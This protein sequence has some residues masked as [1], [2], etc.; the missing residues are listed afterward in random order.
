[1]VSTV[2][3]ATKN[4]Y[5]LDLYLSPA[6]A[7][8]DQSNP[9]GPS[10]R[11]AH[12]ST[13][14]DCTPETFLEDVG[15]VRE[16]F[17]K[18]SLE[19]ETYHVILSHS[20]EELDP[21]SEFEVWL[22]HDFAREQMARAFPGRQIKIVTQAD[23]GR[24]EAAGTAEKIWVKG[25]VHSHC[26][27]A[28]VA[29]EAV[30][31]TWRDAD[32]NSS[33]AH[34]PAGRAFSSAMKN[35]HR[36]RA[37]TDEVVLQRFQYDNQ[38]FMQSCR[39]HARTAGMGTGDR[40][41]LARQAEGKSSHYDELRMRLRIARAQATDWDDYTARLAADGVE[42]KRR[43]GHGDGV[44]YKWLDTPPARAGGRSGV[45]D[46]YKYAAV[47]EQCE[48][49]AQ[50]LKRGEEL[51]TPARSLVVPTSSLAQD[52][53]RP[54][55][56]TE[57][58]KPP[59]QQGEDSYAAHVRQTGGTYEGRAA[60]A[61]ATGEP[62][63]GVT[64][65]RDTDDRV[66][67]AVDAGAGPLVVDVDPA[68]LS[69]VH[70]V[71]S[72]EAAVTRAEARAAETIQSAKDE[73]T[74]IRRQARADEAARVRT[75][76]AAMRPQ[77][78]AEAEAAGRQHGQAA[79][80]RD[81]RPALVTAARVE[82][83]KRGHAEGRQEVTDELEAARKDRR[84]AAE[85]LREVSGL[86]PEEAAE[87]VLDEH[88]VK[89]RVALTWYRVPKVAYDADGTPHRVTGADGKPAVT[90]AWEQMKTDVAHGPGRTDDVTVG[91]ARRAGRQDRQ[92]L[93]DRAERQKAR[94]REKRKDKGFG[95]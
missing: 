60:Q 39:E 45:G 72:R 57:D 67:A 3:S 49:N 50:S 86:T 35:I 21:D 62:G 88:T 71:E 19:L 78:I 84:A 34:Y 17:A 22:A 79:W 16:D 42:V 59:W 10:V 31:L 94:S 2:I 25:K 15:R 68:L 40:K 75:E 30:E 43:G 12:C 51:A 63:E 69:R 93:A 92:N 13:I 36:V 27:I 80:E 46:D 89:A 6:T 83:F 77:V 24:W 52:R 74:T 70:E 20:H 73:A 55:Y 66:T 82:G 38:A 1:M 85:Q 9:G 5:G 4:A 64:L 14:G 32:G 44:S 47:V 58:G 54:V 87:R 26:Q 76:W 41:T 56:L 7:A 81:E 37:V 33:T 95:L 11:V 90:N 18:T 8:H 29:E 28:N 48:R 23:N 91:K 61:L 53:P 65:T